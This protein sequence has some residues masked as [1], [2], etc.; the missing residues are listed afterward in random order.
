MSKSSKSIV[1]HRGFSVVELMIAMAI[2][3]IVISQVLVLFSSHVGAMAEQTLSRKAQQEIR[4]ILHFMNDDIQRTGYWRTEDLEKNPYTLAELTETC[5]RYS[6][7]K[8]KDGSY[9]VEDKEQFGFRFK[10]GK[11][12]FSQKATDCS[13]GYW[14]SI[15]DDKLYRLT[16][17]SFSLTHNEDSCL[18]LSQQPHS[19]CTPSSCDYIPYNAED[20]LLTKAAVMIELKYVFNKREKSAQ[21]YIPINNYIKHKALTNGPNKTS[22]C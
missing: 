4:S 9:P 17:L 14:E 21:Q 5:I 1:D 3:V 10:A 13:S 15:N 2:S 20:M 6:Y 22:I 19:N 8:D 16:E 11:I 12:Q 18:N 7:D